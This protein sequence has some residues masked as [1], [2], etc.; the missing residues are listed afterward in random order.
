MG[1]FGVML[2]PNCSVSLGNAQTEHC[3]SSG[4]SCSRICSAGE[5]DFS[6]GGKV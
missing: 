3:M 4:R 5:Q 1:W 6:E 2:R